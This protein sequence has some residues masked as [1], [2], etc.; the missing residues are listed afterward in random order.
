VSR[1]ATTFFSGNDSD[2]KATVAGILQSFGWPADA[3]VDLGDITSARGPEMLLPLWVSLR[4]A[5][6][7][8][9]FNLAV[10]P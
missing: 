6:G 10:V 4:G 9:Q 2:A 7:T 5:R 1:A 3:I 8:N